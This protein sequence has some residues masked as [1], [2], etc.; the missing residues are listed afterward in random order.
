VSNQPSNEI[1]NTLTHSH[2]K[3]TQTDG[4]HRQ[5]SLTRVLG[6]D[7]DRAAV[8][9]LE[10]HSVALRVDDVADHA[11][12]VGGLERTGA[13]HSDSRHGATCGGREGDTGIYVRYGT[14]RQISQ[15][16]GVVV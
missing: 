10:C 14:L 11:D 3:Y 8:G 6:L 2:S 5:H 9:A 15:A 12:L 16:S 4:Q 7:D 13:F 1:P